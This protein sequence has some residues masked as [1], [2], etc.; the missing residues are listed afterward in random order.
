[1]SETEVITETVN[2]LRL[3]RRYGGKFG[4]DELEYAGV[5][6]GEELAYNPRV[7][8]QNKVVG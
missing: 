6:L 8:R 4:G 5:L 7:V 1:M 2:A 3:A